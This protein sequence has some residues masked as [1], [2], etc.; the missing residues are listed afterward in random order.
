M[1]CKKKVV[2]VW[3]IK[4]S[5]SF[6]RIEIMTKKHFLLVPNNYFIIFLILLINY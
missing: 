3:Y 2:S 1:Y 5:T 4:L 6:S